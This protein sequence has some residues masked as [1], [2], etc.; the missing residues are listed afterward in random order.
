MLTA[1]HW[2]HNVE[3]VAK[4][5]YLDRFPRVNSFNIIPWRKDVLMEEMEVTLVVRIQYDFDADIHHTHNK[6]LLLRIYSRCSITG[7]H[8]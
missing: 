5:C 6:Y 2:L 7:N 8:Y 3:T 1:L 4:C